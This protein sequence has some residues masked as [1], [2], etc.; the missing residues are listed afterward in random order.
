[1]F[2]LAGLGNPGKQYARNR[3][4][5]G[6]V[7]VDAIIRQHGFSGCR[8]KF[9]ATVAQGN[10]NGEKILAL[11]PMTYMNRSGQA[12]AAAVGFYKLSPRDVIV[13]HDDLDLACGQLRIKCGGG[14][15]GHNGLRNIDAH[16]GPDYLRLRIGIGH[17]GDKDAVN[18]HVLSDFTASENTCLDPVIDAVA[19]HFPLLIG[20]DCSL[21]MTRLAESRPGSPTPNPVR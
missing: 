8:E 14:H 15:A 12:V 13:I 9:S 21:F 4:N 11:K 17:P 7:V 16:I 6:F 19:E 10:V 5:I 18:P 1:M 2:V 20:G 3:H